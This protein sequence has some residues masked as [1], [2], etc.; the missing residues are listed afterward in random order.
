MP[1]RLTVAGCEGNVNLMIFSR[2]E[3]SYFTYRRHLIT[4]TD[5]SLAE[6]HGFEDQRH[7][8]AHLNDLAGH[9]AQLLVVVQHRV[10]VLYP[11]GVDG[12]VENHPLLVLRGRRSKLA[13]CI[14]N[15]TIRPLGLGWG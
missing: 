14:G 6:V 8:V 15:D 12:T 11:D 5:R 2:K 3:L 9:E 7:L 13:E 1:Q 4:Q 10:H